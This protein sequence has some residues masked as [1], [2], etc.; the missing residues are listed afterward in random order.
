MKCMYS[1]KV[2]CSECVSV[3]VCVYVCSH[4]FNFNI[5]NIIL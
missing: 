3:C 5:I 2:T 4:D 1:Y